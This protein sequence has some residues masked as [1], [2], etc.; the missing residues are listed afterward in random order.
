MKDA[1]VQLDLALMGHI[2]EPSKSEGIGPCRK[3]SEAKHAVTGYDG[4]SRFWP[5]ERR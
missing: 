3:P 2:P 5:R 4:C 1:R